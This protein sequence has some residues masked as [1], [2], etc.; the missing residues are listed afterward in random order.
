MRTWSFS[1]TFTIVISP[2]ISIQ[3]VPQGLWELTPLRNHT[4]DSQK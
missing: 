3:L 4:W 1:P 2:T